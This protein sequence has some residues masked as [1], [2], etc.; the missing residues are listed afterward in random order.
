LACECTP[1][2]WAFASRR[3]S[4]FDQLFNPR[5]QYR[6]TGV[7]LLELAECHDELVCPRIVYTDL[8][9]FLSSLL[10]KAIGEANLH[11]R[12]LK[13]TMT[14]H[15]TLRAGLAIRRRSNSR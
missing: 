12:S 9:S 6:S 4:P 5:Q 13:V 1:T 7:I 10:C 8:S 2:A 15:V 11:S 14:R 3:N